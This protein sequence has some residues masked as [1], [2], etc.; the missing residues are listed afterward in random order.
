M[1]LISLESPDQETLDRLGKPVRAERVRESFQKMQE[2]NRC[3]RNIEVTC[4]FVLGG[5]LHD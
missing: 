3:R 2:V 4:N 5:D 1:I